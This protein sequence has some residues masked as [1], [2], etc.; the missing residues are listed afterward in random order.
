MKL[1]GIV[2]AMTLQLLYLDGLRISFISVMAR[3]CACASACCHGCVKV[4]VCACVYVLVFVLVC[5]YL[6][7]C[8]RVYVSVYFGTRKR[9]VYSDTC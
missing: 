3:A 4:C 5:M 9:I 7:V 8:A 2:Y 1:S 6:C